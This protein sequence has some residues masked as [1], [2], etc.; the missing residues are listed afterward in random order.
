MSASQKETSLSLQLKRLQVPQTQ[1]LGLNDRRRVSF[2]YDPKDAANMDTESVHCLALNG[3][4]QLK[5]INSTFSTFEET[6]FSSTSI[7]FERSVQTREVNDN[8]DSEIR[9]FLIHL[10]PYFLLKPAHKTL[11]WLV[12]RYHIHSFNV[13]DLFMCILPYHETNYFIRA[14]QMMNFDAGASSLL[15]SWLVN[16]QK[17]GVPL[18]SNT[19]SQHLIND[20]SFL[21]YLINYMNECLLVYRQDEESDDGLRS[22]LSIAIVNLCTSFFTK[23]LVQAIGQQ[24]NVTNKKINDSFVAQL[25]PFLYTSLKP[26]QP[27]EF[28]Q[29][30]YLL[31]AILFQKCTFNKETIEKTLLALIKS[32][33]ESTE[34]GESSSSNQTNVKS[35]LVSMCLIIQSQ[36]KSRQSDNT[37][38]DGGATVI[39]LMQLNDSN[40]FTRA[41]LKKLTKNVER[42]LMIEQ[43]KRL[44][45]EC[46]IDE[47][48]QLLY[49]RLL[50]DILTKQNGSEKSE[51]ESLLRLCLDEVTLSP[52]STLIDH[53]IKVIFSLLANY[54]ATDEAP[55]ALLSNL[56]KEFERKYPQKFENSLKV[57]SKQEN[58]EQ[59][60]ALFSFKS[61]STFKYNYIEDVGANLAICLQHTNE[62]IRAKAIEYIHE[63]AKKNEN[64]DLDFVKSQ[65]EL[66]FNDDSVCVVRAILKF[67]VDL[68]KYFTINELKKHFIEAIF[69]KSSSSDGWSEL[70]KQAI[71]ILFSSVYTSKKAEFATHRV[72]YLDGLVSIGCKLLE[73]KES[74]DLLKSLIESKYVKEQQKGAAKLNANDFYN[75]LKSCVSAHYKSYIDDCTSDLLTSISSNHQTEL[76]TFFVFDLHVHSLLESTPSSSLNQAKQHHLLDKCF[77]ILKQ[78]YHKCDFKEKINCDLKAT[79]E[80]I[81]IDEYLNAIKTNK[82]NTNLYLRLFTK[83]L[84]ISNQLNTNNDPLF[85]Y[86]CIKSSKSPAFIYLLE[87]FI[88]FN[89]NDSNKFFTY[90]QKYLLQIEHSPSNNSNSSSSSE[91]FVSEITKLRSLQI[92]NKYIPEKQ[93]ISEES[94]LQSTYLLSLTSCLTSN[95]EQIR[96]E[97]LNCLEKIQTQLT[98]SVHQQQDVEKQENSSLWYSFIKK[99]LKHSQ[100]IVYDSTYVGHSQL[101]KLLTSNILGEINEAIVKCDRTESI[102][103][104]NFVERNKRRSEIGFN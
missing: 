6:L 89:L 47:F 102:V 85:T 2:L 100:E 90:L 77:Q 41:I 14:L 42:R 4:E 46:K 12:Y 17:S 98:S 32:L 33:K 53:L 87:Q 9:R 70:K 27:N 82:I 5:M 10:S 76:K 26:A 99:L 61:K 22:N 29:M 97:T 57:L 63:N 83:Y 92:L 69:V 52:S 58:I 37:A 3:L 56:L 38:A 95:Y 78:L 65:L 94:F 21:N 40:C 49:E 20:L 1:L 51:E 45:E 59:A 66:R 35:A 43:L 101:S 34:E 48:L 71:E 44:N 74:T 50:V 64:I 31:C 80:T 36:Q 88:K 15:W 84:Q 96:K 8:L 7:N 104:L 103:Y 75:G 62:V 30:S 24:Y 68:L 67:N 93:F 73:Q 18:S 25:L 54:E 11:E 13:N 28:K 72:D 39:S 60:I 91:H 79:N 81:T 19:L 55:I 86:L 16:N 23:S